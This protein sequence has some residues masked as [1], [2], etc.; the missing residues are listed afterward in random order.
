MVNET[1]RA[2]ALR[3]SLE[4][5]KK[6]TADLH[7]ALESFSSEIGPEQARTL[8]AAVSKHETATGEF[9]HSALACVPPTG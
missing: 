2:A 8:K 1:S 5:H 9:L 3:K 6:A 4:Q 7:K